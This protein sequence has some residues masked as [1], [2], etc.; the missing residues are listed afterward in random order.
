[1][2]FRILIIILLLLPLCHF[3]AK[4]DSVLPVLQ[5]IHKN[6]IKFNPTPMLLWDIRNLTFSYERILNPRQSISLELG[7]LAMPRLFEDT[8]AQLVNITSHKK[9]GVNATIEYRFYISKLNRRPIPAG[10]YIGPYL[11]F[12]GYKFRN[13]LDILQT[14]VDKSATIEGNFW[15]FN[16]G[17]EVGYQFI[18]WKRLSLDLILLGPSLTYYGGSTGISGNLDPGQI[19]AIHEALY[20][21]LKERFPA[22]GYFPVNKSFRQTGKLDVLLFGFRYL[23]QVGFHF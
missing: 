21:K 2:N 5:P 10:L 1:M 22:M 17:F 12:Y 23:V 3:A 16:L 11:T 20:D 9:Y 4:N 19:Q 6:V 15:A 8:I 18:F 14:S 13:G 7:F